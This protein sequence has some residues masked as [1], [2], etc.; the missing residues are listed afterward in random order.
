MPEAPGLARSLRFWDLVF[1][2]V[3]TVIGSGIFLVP[4]SVLRETGAHAGLALTV[5]TVGGVLSLLGALTYAELGGL[6]PN[7]GG[8]Y[9]YLREAFGS[10]PAFL[11]GWTMFLAIASG[12]IATLAVAA[13]GYLGQLVA[14]GPTGQKVAALLIIAAVT[15]VNVRGTRQGAGVQNA[16]TT[17]KVGAILLLSI[18]LFAAPAPTPAP[19]TETPGPAAWPS[20]L[21]LPV[22]QGAGVAMIGVLWAYEGWQYVTFSAGEMIDPQRTFPRALV[23]GTAALVGIYLLANVAYLKALGPTGVASSDQVAADAV[24]AL[25]GSFAAKA[26]AVPI[27]ISMVGAANGLALTAPRA[28]Y[29]MAR[30]GVFFRRL[31]EVHPRFRTP[32]LAILTSS[33]WAMVLATS[34]TFQQLFTYVV[35][36]VWIFH[37]L[38][39]VSVFVLRRKLPS[40]VRPFRVPGYPWTPIAFLLAAAAIIGNTLASR[41]R[42]SLVGLAIVLFGAPVFYVWRRSRLVS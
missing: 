10:L 33:A 34:G 8:L 35:F 9:V 24:R 20:P 32:A 1:I 29:A 39:A 23:L 11:F 16:A 13:S 31:A 6:F 26:L 22:L 36:A 37:A 28:Y 38:A 5:W 2:V 14:L 17:V 12:S 15:W 41:P 30:D 4:G 19:A 27:I 7:A 21:T 25:Y 40:A 42:E 18:L 3:G